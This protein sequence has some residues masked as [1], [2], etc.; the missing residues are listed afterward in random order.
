MWYDILGK[1]QY[2]FWNFMQNDG[3]DAGRRG[4]KGMRAMEIANALLEISQSEGLPISNLHLQKMLYYAQGFSYAFDHRELF[5]DDFEA[6]KD[7]PVIPKVYNE[8]RRYG[9]SPVA[10]T[11]AGALGHIANKET[12]DFLQIIVQTVGKKDPWALVEKTHAEA[13]WRENYSYSDSRIIPKKDI[14]TYFEQAIGGEDK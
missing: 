8:F 5:E 9:A 3:S 14:Q 7:G 10:P 4:V 1:L 13:P 2:L 11:E 6:W 12:R